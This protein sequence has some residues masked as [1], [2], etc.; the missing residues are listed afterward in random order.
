MYP[1]DWA[2]RSQITCAVRPGV[3]RLRFN[4][5]FENSKGII[6]SGHVSKH[7]AVEKSTNKQKH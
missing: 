2:A 7:I 6:C 4:L 1:A 5:H 3:F